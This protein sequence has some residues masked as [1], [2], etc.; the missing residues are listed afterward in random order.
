MSLATCCLSLPPRPPVVNQFRS[1]ASWE[2]S[3][4]DRR[5]SCPCQDE[6]PAWI[7]TLHTKSIAMLTTIMPLY[8]PCCAWPETDCSAADPTP[9]LGGG[10]R[11]SVTDFQSFSSASN[12]Q[13]GRMRC[14]RPARQISNTIQKRLSQAVPPSFLL[15]S[16]PSYPS[17]SPVSAP[18]HLLLR[19]PRTMFNWTPAKQHRVL[20][21]IHYAQVAG[22]IAVCILGIARL[23]TR[24]T[25]RPMSRMD[26]WGITVVRAVACAI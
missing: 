16:S 22:A 15:I 20:T 10:S 11:S 7:S 2:N 5:S 21:L 1:A 9:G 24:N 4:G 18:S 17:P 14:V 23:A 6:P 25:S 3:R 8:F 12:S 19:T 26:V 13:R